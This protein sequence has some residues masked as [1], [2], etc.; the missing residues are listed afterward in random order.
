MLWVEQPVGV[1]FSQGVPN[2]TNEVELGLELAGFYKSFVDT[3]AV[4]NY[5]VYLTGERYFCICILTSDEDTNWLQLCWILCP[6]HR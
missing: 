2:I 5:D 3:F 1:G 6:L 4:N